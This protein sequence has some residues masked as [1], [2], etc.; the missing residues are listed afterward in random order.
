MKKYWHG[1]HT[2]HRNMYHLIW[3]PKYRKKILVGKIK[4]RVEE[5]IRECAEMNRW[6]IQAL[7]V[8][9][10]HVHMLIQLPPSVSVIKA[11]QLFK[12]ISS[13]LIIS[14]IPEVKK[15]LW[16]RDFWADGFFSETS[17]SVSEERIK[18][19]IQNQ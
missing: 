15:L 11:V 17:G 19:Y 16:G 13:R 12:G 7:N 2:T 4:T 5:L 18:E 6:E 1:A 3:L 10:D 9:V 14:E 8:Q